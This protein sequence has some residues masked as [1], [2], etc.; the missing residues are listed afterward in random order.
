M[1]AHPMHAVSTATAAKVRKGISPDILP[2]AHNLA[3]LRTIH[4]DRAE[5]HRRMFRNLVPILRSVTCLRDAEATQRDGIG[6]LCIAFH[7]ADTDEEAAI[8]EARE[9]GAAALEGLGLQLLLRRRDEIDCAAGRRSMPT[10]LPQGYGGLETAT[11]GPGLPDAAAVLDDHV[12]AVLGGR[13]V[14]EL[15]ARRGHADRRFA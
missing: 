11:L 10:L 2:I 14:A 1:A 4:P 7:G 13:P 9:A 8:R 12:V 6:L 5:R 15:G 3:G